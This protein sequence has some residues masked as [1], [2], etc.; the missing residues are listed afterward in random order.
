MN[1]TIR[2]KGTLFYADYII[3]HVIGLYHLFADFFHY[4]F[5]VQL[6]SKIT[7]ELLNIML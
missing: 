3:Q 1:L 6:D 2:D 4:A 5:G 7:L